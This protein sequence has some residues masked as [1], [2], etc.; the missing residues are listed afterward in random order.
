MSLGLTAARI[1]GKGPLALRI[2]NRNDFRI[3]A[4]V[5]GQT[6]RKVQ[7]AAKRPLKLGA[8][9]ITVPAKAART[10]RLSL[11]RAVRRLLARNGKVA[12]RLSVRITDPIGNV[13][14]FTKRLTPRLRREVALRPRVWRA[15]DGISRDRHHS[16]R[17]HGPGGRD[18]SGAGTTPRCSASKKNVTPGGPAIPSIRG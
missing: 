3:V 11:P 12:L 8:K 6:V 5:S 15:C 1:P 4:R 10:V 2:A 18:A 9:R 17:F 13:R 7:A 14:T 16:P